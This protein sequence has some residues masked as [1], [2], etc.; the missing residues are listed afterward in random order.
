MFIYVQGVDAVYA[1]GIANGAKSLML[2]EKKEYGYTGGFEDSWG[3]QW[4][5]VEG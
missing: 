4:W 3:N 2:P 1:K 5:I